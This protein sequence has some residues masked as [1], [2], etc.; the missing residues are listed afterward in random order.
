MLFRS[1]RVL[2]ALPRIARHAYLLVVVVV[3]WALFYFTDTARLFE[4][5]RALAG[6]GSGGLVGSST[7]A[8]IGAR[9]IWLCLALAGCLPVVAWLRQRGLVFNLTAPKTSIGFAVLL[10]ADLALLLASSASL[11]GQN[12]NPFIYF[13]F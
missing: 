7:A 8:D 4:C 13:R 9:A 12:Y 11:V 1:T 5:F 6:A 3:G 10:V 2:D